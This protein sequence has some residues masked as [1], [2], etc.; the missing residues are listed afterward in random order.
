MEIT[1]HEVQ[2]QANT[3]NIYLGVQFSPDDEIMQKAKLTYPRILVTL[4]NG[5]HVKT[6]ILEKG[7]PSNYQLNE[8]D[9]AKVFDYIQ[10]NLT[11]KDFM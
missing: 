8:A 10:N 11:Q 6:E 9:E 2:R 4:E 7:T 3:H 1:G 5:E